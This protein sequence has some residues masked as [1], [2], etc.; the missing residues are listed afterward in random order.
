MTAAAGLGGDE[1][2]AAAGTAQAPTPWRAVQ[3]AA[4]DTLT[5][6]ERGR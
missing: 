4:F 5:K 1:A 3:R 6:Q 2:L